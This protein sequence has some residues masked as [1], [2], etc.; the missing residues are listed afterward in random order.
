MFQG[1]RVLGPLNV[2]ALRQAIHDVVARHE[3]LRATFPSVRRIPHVSVD[4]GTFQGLS[5]I[6]LPA[7][8]AATSEAEAMKIVEDEANAPFDLGSGPLFRP[9]LIRVNPSDHF[10]IYVLHHIV[11]DEWSLR[12]LYREIGEAYRAHS[13]GIKPNLPELPIQY[14]DFALWQRK[15]L[16][17]GAYESSRAYWQTALTGVSENF[18]IPYDDVPQDQPRPGMRQHRWRIAADL[19]HEIDRLGREL[20]ATPFMTTLAAFMT[21]LHGWVGS[22]DIVIGTP[23]A[24][25]Q[26][27]ELENLIGYFANT[28]IVRGDATGDPSFQDFLDQVRIRVLEG[29]DHQDLPF[30][31]V[32]EALNPERGNIGAPIFKVM[33]THRESI[34]PTLM[35]PA[36]DPALR[37][38]EI[39]VTRQ[40]SKSDLW[41]S[42]KDGGEDR[43]AALVYDTSL[44]DEATIES[45]ATDFN[46]LLRLIISAPDTRLSALRASLSPTAQRR[47]RA[48]PPS[49]GTGVRPDAPT[50]APANEIAAHD[51]YTTRMLDIWSRVLGRRDIG[52]D[53]DFFDL[54]GHSML[55]LELF[56]EI[57]RD[58][59]I[60]L[61]LSLLFVAPTVSALVRAIAQ[62]P[63][64]PR[65]K[66]IIAIQPLGRKKPIFAVPYGGGSVIMYRSLAQSLGADQPF[67][68]LEHPGMND[69]KTLERVEEIASSYLEEIRHLH[70]EQTCI[71]IGNCSGALV[72]F[73]LARLLVSEGRPVHRV[74]LVN[75]PSIGERLPRSAKWRSWQRLKANFF[76]LGELKGA[77]RLYFFNDRLNLIWK[78]F[79]QFLFPGPDLS[80]NQERIF[81]ASRAAVKNY[82]PRHYEGAVT[83]VL[84]IR[85]GLGWQDV[86]ASPPEVLR[87]YG[88]SYRKKIYPPLEGDPGGHIREFVAR[89]G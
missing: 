15:Q 5:I 16:Q 61:P 78:A 87:Y 41:L 37:I 17:S 81:E 84:G 7:P 36:L 50:A 8:T 73:E 72:A 27:P 11:C 76:A 6:E 24:D 39:E 69:G 74:I 45:V 80:I 28:M 79:H 13:L 62:G 25:R 30:D 49:A 4:P 46:R 83:L 31:Q 29:I 55:A 68:G 12:N 23:T 9:F 35:D 14:A 56:A 42:I 1:F 88:S 47:S 82:S 2:A 3:T 38:S 70:P 63:D 52:V 66:Q 89:D 86:C 71:L 85:G 48:M 33:F 57:D 26:R 64:T 58:F 77:E 19:A 65:M 40:Q 67:Y 43:W 59:G 22:D 32:V 34:P 20:G 54:G 75:P 21:L 53:D 18:T 10:L 60:S 51:T 44:Y